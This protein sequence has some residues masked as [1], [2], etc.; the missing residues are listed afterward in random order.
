MYFFYCNFKYT[1]I[2]P[3]SHP[4]HHVI[5][6]NKT[7]ISSSSLFSDFAKILLFSLEPYR[8]PTTKIFHN[9]SC[10]TSDCS[11]LLPLLQKKL[12]IGEW[13][14]INMNEFY[15][16]DFIYITLSYLWQ[17]CTG[18]ICVLTSFFIF[19]EIYF[20]HKLFFARVCLKYVSHY[21][22]T[23]IKNV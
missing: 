19:Y 23:F 2:L 11:I 3:T 5:I 22:W 16:L 1:E 17:I 13:S 21:L 15:L 18:H 6:I 12:N 9:Y 7:L 10:R 8:K 4:H 14:K 20:K